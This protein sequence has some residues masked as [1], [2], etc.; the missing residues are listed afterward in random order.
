MRACCATCR[1]PDGRVVLISFGSPY[2]L[3]QVPAVSA[4]VGAYGA[5]DSSQ[6]AAV[7]AVFG[8][9]PV[10]GKVPV[11]LPGFYA[12]GDGLQIPRHEMTLRAAAPAEAGFRPDG[13][14]EVDRVVEAAVAARAFPGAVLA[15]GKDG[16]LAH[17]RPFGHLSYDDERAG[18]A[19]GH[20]VRPGQPHQ[21]HRDHDHGHD[22]GGRGQARR[23]QARLRVPAR[24]PRR[25]QGQG[26]GLAPPDPLVGHRLVGAP[27]QGAQGQGRVPQA[28]PGHGPRLR[29]G[30][31][32]RLQRPRRPPAGRDPGARGRAGR[33]TRSRARG[34]SSRSA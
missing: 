30:H 14:A 32:V 21:G 27:L 5:A 28:R 24:V 18:G 33:S 19:R 20:D 11:S 6:R 31:E 15:V 9:Y 7:A 23:Q 8:E 3:R 10:S 34:C 22:P 13:L 16:A 29:A 2:L 12:F 1:R 17:L 25:G 4:Y 26:D